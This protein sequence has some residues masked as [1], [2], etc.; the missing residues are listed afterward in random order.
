MPGLSKAQIFVS[1]WWYWE[2]WIG[3]GRSG[4]L[5]KFRRIW[6]YLWVDLL[7]AWI[8]IL[9]NGAYWWLF[10][11][12]D[13]FCWFHFKPVWDIAFW[14]CARSILLLAGNGS[15]SL[16]LTSTAMTFELK[17]AKQINARKRTIFLKVIVV[18]KW[19]S[20]TNDT[21]VQMLNLDS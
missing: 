13:I 1:K 7:S 15:K 9:L 16:P 10:K 4:I 19:P 18:I 11:I 3:K 5:M 8:S 6:W 20:G 17:N 12:A 14:P 2:Y 21:M